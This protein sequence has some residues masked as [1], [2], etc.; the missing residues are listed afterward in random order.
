M[1]EQAGQGL[2]RADLPR[3][4]ALGDGIHRH[5]SLASGL[6]YPLAD[7][8][9]VGPC[10]GERALITILL[11]L[12]GLAAAAALTIN[13]LPIEEDMR[14]LFQ[15][16]LALVIMALGLLLVLVYL[17]VAPHLERHPGLS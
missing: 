7:R 16:V 1:P 13:V 6:F 17:P 14:R 11:I 5:R 8:R 15:V 10:P 2:P 4:M 9:R 12:L 3:P